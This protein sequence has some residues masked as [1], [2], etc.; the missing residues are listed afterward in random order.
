MDLTLQS[1]FLNVGDLN[2]AVEFYRD[3]FAIDVVSE[4]DRV[5]IAVAASPTGSPIEADA[6]KNLGNAI[7]SDA[8]SA[9]T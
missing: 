5:Q 6:W 1:I 4:A 9:D 8:G 3:V 2:Q 7:W